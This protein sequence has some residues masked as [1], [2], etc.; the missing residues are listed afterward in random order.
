LDK[1]IALAGLGRRLSSGSGVA[2]SGFGPDYSCRAAPPVARLVG[3]QSD[4]LQRHPLSQITQ[5]TI[6]RLF[7][8]D[9]QPTHKNRVFLADVSRVSALFDI[10]PNITSSANDSAYARLMG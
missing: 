4:K 7:T 5:L 6:N 3:P 1:A 10:L 2:L 8:D 9:R